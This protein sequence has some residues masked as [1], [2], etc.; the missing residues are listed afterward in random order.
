MATVLVMSIVD[1]I[2]FSQSTKILPDALLIN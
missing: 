1:A 2:Y